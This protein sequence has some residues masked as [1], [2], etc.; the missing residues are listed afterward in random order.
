MERLVAM[1]TSLPQGKASLRQHPLRGS[2]RETPGAGTGHGASAAGRVCLSSPWPHLGGVPGHQG[3]RWLQTRHEGLSEGVSMRTEAM[4]LLRPSGEGVEPR[5]IPHQRG[6]ASVPPVPRSLSKQRRDAARAPRVA[7]PLAHPAPALCYLCPI[8]VLIPVPIPLSPCPHPCV[9]VFPSSHSA[10]LFSHE[11]S[12]RPRCPPPPGPLRSFDPFCPRWDQGREEPHGASRSNAGHGRQR[13]P[14]PLRP[15][16]FLGWG[17]RKEPPYGTQRQSSA[18][19]PGLS[20][21]GSPLPGPARGGEAEEEEEEEEPRSRRAGVGAGAGREVIHTPPHHRGGGDGAAVGPSR[22]KGK[23]NLPLPLTRA[24]P[25]PQAGAFRGAAG[26]SAWHRHGERYCGTAHPAE[27]IRPCA[28]RSA[29]CAS[30]SCPTFPAVPSSLELG[31]RNR[32]RGPNARPRVA[33]MGRAAGVPQAVRTGRGS[34][35]AVPGPKETLAAHPQAALSRAIWASLLWGC[36]SKRTLCITSAAPGHLP[37]QPHRD[38]QPQTCT[39]GTL[40]TQGREQW[41]AVI[42]PSQITGMEMGMEAMGSGNGDGGPGGGKGGGGGGGGVEVG[43][44]MG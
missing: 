40:E 11:G 41:W 34:V 26:R 14:A 4:A 43:M 12:G 33:P 24:P 10:A 16:P 35:P 3:W 1:S 42:C 18:P 8:S 5:G 15:R 17:L 32:T 13:P 37:Q 38:P 20:P 23:Q 31:T 7:A 36:G 30:R 21:A 19:Q 6:C 28:P 44:G 22:R 25:P 9:P 29:P 39:G 27:R 2:P